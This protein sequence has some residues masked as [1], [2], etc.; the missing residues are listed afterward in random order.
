MLAFRDSLL[1]ASP[2]D[3]KF[4]KATGTPLYSSHMIDLSEEDVEYNVATTA[5]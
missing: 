5:K 3:E 4:F 1:T 2:L